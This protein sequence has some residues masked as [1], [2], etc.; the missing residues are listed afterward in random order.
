MNDGLGYGTLFVVGIAGTIAGCL[1]GDKR[2]Q[3]K[4]GIRWSDA[5]QKCAKTGLP[6]GSDL[7]E[8]ERKDLFAMLKMHAD[9]IGVTAVEITER[10]RLAALDLMGRTGV[11]Q[12]T[13]D[14][15][16]GVAALLAEIGGTP[17]HTDLQLAR[18]AAVH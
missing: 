4:A 16:D 15:K 17:T 2:G 1:L 13:T 7:N 3:K 11:R 5:V 8:A 10:M 18:E 12:F 9:E 6:T 14:E